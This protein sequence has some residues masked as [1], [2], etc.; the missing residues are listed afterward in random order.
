MKQYTYII[1]L[2]FSL[3]A[4][5]QD[6]LEQSVEDEYPSDGKTTFVLQASDAS[7]IYTRSGDAETDEVF[8]SVMLMGF[9]TDGNLSVEAYQQL[10]ENNNTVRLYISGDVTEV[11][12]LCNVQDISILDDVKTLD[13]LKS[14]SVTM[15]QP[16]GAYTGKYVMSGK[17]ST[18]SGAS[19]YT[20]TVTALP[21]NLTLI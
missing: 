1:I 15:T 20:I 3:L 14:V 13:D 4:A 6:D 19:S 8:E 12:A 7:A 18:D 10:I 2:L 17:T 16:D 5:C 9:D 21:P 11:Y